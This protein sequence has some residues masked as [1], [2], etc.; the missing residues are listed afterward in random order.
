MHTNLFIKDVFMDTGGSMRCP[1]CAYKGK[2]F[3]GRCAVCGYPLD[4]ETQETTEGSIAAMH[5]PF[6]KITSQF[7]PITNQYSP[8]LNARST[9]TSPLENTPEIGD[10]LRNGRYRLEERIALPASQQNQGMAWTAYDLKMSSRFVVVREV[11]FSG[12]QASTAAQ[13]EYLANKIAQ[14]LNKLGEHPG[15]P[16][17][18]DLFSENGNYFLVFLYPQGETLT[19]L[20]KRWH[21]ALPEFMLA[22]YAWQLCDILALL[23]DQQPPIVHGAINPNTILI[24]EDNQQAL[25]LHLPL[26]PIKEPIGKIDDG[27]SMYLAPEQV[28]GTITPASDLY[29]LA[30]TLY[31]AVTGSHPL[32][33]PRSFYPPARRLNEQVSPD[34]ELILARELRLSVTQ[35]YSNPREM[36]HDI[37]TLINAYTT[38]ATK[39]VTPLQPSEVPV[40]ALKEEPLQK[41]TFRNMRTLAI[42]MLIGVM[43]ILGLLLFVVFR[44]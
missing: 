4:Q 12:D 8:I 9:T 41:S 24:S 36:Q 11:K 22:E 17:V 3:N 10:L 34:M 18:V 15:L 6:P 23:A 37:T 30:A 5:Q 44:A 39:T 31:H 20:L 28:H 25:L 33:R 32:E 40:L 26:L 35:R 21:N 43:V 29:S 14:R 42:P 7:S 38:L 27:I 13:K 1:R 2:L 16:S 19:A